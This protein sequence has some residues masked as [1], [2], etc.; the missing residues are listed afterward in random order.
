MER[1][2]IRLNRILSVLLLAGVLLPFGGWA[3]PVE[4]ARALLAAGKPGEVDAKLGSL[5]E[6]RPVPDEALVV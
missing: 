6:R 4:E 1:V 5:L 3:G 2:V